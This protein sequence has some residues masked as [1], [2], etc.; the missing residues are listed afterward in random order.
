MARASLMRSRCTRARLA[1]RTRARVARGL[2]EGASWLAARAV[3]GELGVAAAA[4]IAATAAAAAAPRSAS[5][6]FFPFFLC[7]R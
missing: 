4:D 6:R 2:S 5:R 3:A 1:A 7:G